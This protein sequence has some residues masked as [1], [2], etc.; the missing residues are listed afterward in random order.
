[1]HK[2]RLPSLLIPFGNK[3]KANCHGSN[4][5]SHDHNTRWTPLRQLRG[6]GKLR[7]P[8][9]RWHI[10]FVRDFAKIFHVRWVRH[11]LFFSLCQH[12]D[13]RYEICPTARFRTLVLSSLKHRRSLDCFAET[14]DMVNLL[15]VSRSK[16]D[17]LPKRLKTAS[18]NPVLR[19]AYRF[20]L[21][22]SRRTV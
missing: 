11:F 3:I 9:R 6:V 19:S 12:R 16:I 18:S 22:L 4:A 15:I 7:V 21:D 2:T 5:R 14:G 10:L 8:T 17:L 20:Q 1:M 13:T